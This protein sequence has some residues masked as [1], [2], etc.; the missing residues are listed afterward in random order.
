MA[1]DTRALWPRFRWWW[2][3]CCQARTRCRFAP[4]GGRRA[5]AP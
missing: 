1:I 4:G 2:N 5:I 3:A